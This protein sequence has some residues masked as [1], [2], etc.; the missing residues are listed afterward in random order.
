MKI[1]Y[2]L[3]IPPKKSTKKAW[4]FVLNTYSGC[5]RWV[6][7][8]SS[9]QK[10]ERKGLDWNVKESHMLFLL[11]EMELLLLHTSY[12]FSEY[13]NQRLFVALLFKRRRR[14]VAFFTCV[15]CAKMHFLRSRRAWLMLLAMTQVLCN[16]FKRK[17]WL[18]FVEKN[19]RHFHFVRLH[20]LLVE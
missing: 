7:Y 1:Q 19:K 11:L 3:K 4:P 16:Y 6:Y 8:C 14:G 13:F 18:L 5:C 12:L 15:S 20:L 9:C 10:Q 17:T 2:G